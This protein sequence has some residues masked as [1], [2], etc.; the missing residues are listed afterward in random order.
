[1]RFVKHILFGLILIYTS[2]WGQIN[3]LVGSMGHDKALVT[4]VENAKLTDLIWQKT[5]VEIKTIKIAE[6]DRPYGMM[7]GIPGRPQLLLSRG[8]YDNF[9]PDEVE[10]VVLHKAGHYALAHSVKELLLG[11]LLLVVG[12]WALKRTRKPARGIVG[13]IT[14][15]LIFGVAMIRLGAFNELQA[16][17]YAVTRMTNPEGM[18]AA[19]EKFRGHYGKSLTQ[20][21]NKLIQ[22]MFYRGNPY[23]NR[24]KIAEEEMEK[25]GELQVN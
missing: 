11:L 24:I 23:D 25:R 13:A 12:I 4:V 14:L 16:D 5:N 7:V 19:T 8:L 18:I 20:N 17:N 2:M 1:M 15:G 6:S 9:A 21:D 22:W 10:Y 3:L